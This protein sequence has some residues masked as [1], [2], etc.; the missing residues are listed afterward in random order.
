VIL[1]QLWSTHSWPKPPYV[2][3]HADRTR[4]ANF[5]LTDLEDK[6]TRR[7]ARIETWENEKPDAKQW[8][9]DALGLEPAVAAIQARGG[10]VVYVR[11]PTCD[12]LWDADERM[13]P[14][15]QFWDQLAARTHAIAIHFKDDPTLASFDCPDTSHLDMRDAPAFTRA[16]LQVLRDRGVFN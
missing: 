3:T 6:R 12:A 15:A 5:S 10:K 8:L 2:T 11:M 14:K 16:L 4:Y 1:G 9:Q 13:F 7:L